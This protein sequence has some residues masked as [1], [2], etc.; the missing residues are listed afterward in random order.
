MTTVITTIMTNEPELITSERARNIGKT[1]EH[2][3]APAVV[4]A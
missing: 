1:Y 4:A 3:F 2:Y